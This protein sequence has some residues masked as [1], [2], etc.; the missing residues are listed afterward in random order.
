MFNII[1]QVTQ[2]HAQT[3]TTMNFYHI[4]I[5]KAASIMYNYYWIKNYYCLA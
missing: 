1:L 3:N 2:N 4:K 5:Q